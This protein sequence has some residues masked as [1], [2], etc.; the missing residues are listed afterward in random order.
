M[1]NGQSILAIIPARRGSKR[2]PGK[3][4]KILGDKPL[5][6]WTIEAAKNSQY[7]D[8]IIVS[9]DSDKIAKVAK[10]WGVA[11]PFE[12]PSYLSTD[13]ASSEDVIVH[14]LNW[15]EENEGIL[16]DYFILLQPTSPLRQTKD[17]DQALELMEKKNA[18]SVV[19]VVKAVR[20]IE[21]YVIL[22]EDLKLTNVVKELNNGTGESDYSQTYYYNGAIKAVIVNDFIEMNKFFSKNTI[23]YVM[24]QN[25]SVDIDNDFDFRIAEMILKNRSINE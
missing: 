20:P 7:I 11:V 4:I 10:N 21:W 13:E 15:I 9:T 18:S 22:G 17:I 14:T 25:R 16:F 23:A 24:P 3:N 2:L 12:R 6:A 1:I 8:H 19:S 5:I